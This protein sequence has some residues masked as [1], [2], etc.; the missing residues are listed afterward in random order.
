[1]EKVEIVTEIDGKTIKKKLDIVFGYVVLVFTD[2][3]ICVLIPEE[4]YGDK[5]IEMG[6]KPEDVDGLYNLLQEND[7]VANQIVGVQD[8][9]LMIQQNRFLLLHLLVI[10]YRSLLLSCPP[11]YFPR[12]I[13][14]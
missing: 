14:A 11:E 1:M 7:L 2:N 5:Q 8:Y 4:H 9:Y 12:N 13:S 10:S 6:R 3:T